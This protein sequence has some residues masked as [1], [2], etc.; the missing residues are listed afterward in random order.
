MRPFD[1]LPNFPFTTS[2]MMHNCYLN[3]WCARARVCVCVCVCVC[4]YF[5]TCWLL[6]IARRLLHTW[7]VRINDPLFWILL[8]A[9]AKFLHL[10]VW[11]CHILPPKTKYP[12]RSKLER[13]RYD[14]SQPRTKTNM[15]RKDNQDKEATL[16]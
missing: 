2:E 4:L 12:D 9:S 6:P 7:D 10:R 11:K 14:I 8:R 3:T 16:I 5:F 1:V 15:W 13:K